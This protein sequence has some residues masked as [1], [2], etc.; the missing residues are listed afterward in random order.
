M[1]NFNSLFGATPTEEKIVHAAEPVVAPAVAESTT[2][3]VEEKPQ[4]ATKFSDVLGGMINPDSV[5]THIEDVHKPDTTKDGEYDCESVNVFDFININK[6]YGDFKLF[7]NLNLTIKDFKDEGQF[8]TFIGQSGCGK[9]QLLKMIAGISKPDSGII[10]LYGND[11]KESDTIPMVFQQYSSFEWMTVLENVALP[12]K[13]AGIDKKT[14][15][16]KA[17]QL[18]KLVNLEGHEH[19]FCRYGVLSG[20]QLQRVSIA[21]SLAC[22]SKL[23]MLDEYS[24]GLDYFTKFELQDLLLKI[25]NDRTIDRTFLMVTHDISEAVYLSNRI[26]VLE[27]NPCKIKEV[28]DIKFSQPRTHAIRETQEFKDYQSKILSVLNETVNTK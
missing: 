1:G 24:S 19:K 17:M 26:Y 16:E 21:R 27:P 22:D 4:Y 11:I 12:M 8:I 10:K 7:E 2:E 3:P 23:L 6:S 9:T 25:F 28:I 18:I 5:E 15:E 20:G 13:L 14:R